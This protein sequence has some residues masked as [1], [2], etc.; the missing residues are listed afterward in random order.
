MKAERADDEK[1]VPTD[2]LIAEVVGD[3]DLHTRGD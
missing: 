2:D 1:G 3:G